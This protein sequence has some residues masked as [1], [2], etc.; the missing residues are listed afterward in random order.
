G[1]FSRNLC[2]ANRYCSCTLRR[3]SSSRTP[4]VF[5][6]ASKIPSATEPSH[7][8]TIDSCPRSTR[9]VSSCVSTCSDPP[10]ASGPTGANGKATLSTTICIALNERPRDKSLNK[11]F[12]YFEEGELRRLATPTREAAGNLQLSG[13][14]A[15]TLPFPASTFSN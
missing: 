2:R 10:M 7:A 4:D 13:L 9:A 6:V 3:S 14:Y 11:G 1:H 5:G 15:I 8:I 12:P